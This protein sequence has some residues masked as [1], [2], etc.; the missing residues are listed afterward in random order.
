MSQYDP[1]T[2]AFKTTCKTI[3]T[4]R[5]FHEEG[6]PS[7]KE[8]IFTLE[9]ACKALVSNLQFNT[10]H[11]TEILTLAILADIPDV[12]EA[13]FSQH[14]AAKNYLPAP[15]SQAMGK[16]SHHALS[17]PHLRALT[18]VIR[19]HGMVVSFR[20]R[21]NALTELLCKK[22]CAQRFELFLVL[23]DQRPFFDD[24]LCDI[25]ATAGPSIAEVFAK[26][27]QNPDFSQTAGEILAQKSF[28]ALSLKEL[29]IFILSGTHFED[30]Y[31]PHEAE[32]HLPSPVMEVVRLTSSNHGR[33]EIGRREPSLAELVARPVN[34][35]F[36]GLVSD[37][38]MVLDAAP[39]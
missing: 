14:G 11:G 26:H 38:G 19:N 36:F 37:T 23:K 17:T 29:S 21:P 35:P 7:L 28:D 24:D 8:A 32:K 39:K 16:I 9:Q 5:Y 13:I 20:D 2:E 31:L 6:D 33:L 1:T 22:D 10:E 34:E 3:A 4:L 18:T 27:M 25:L 12:L 15:T 30:H